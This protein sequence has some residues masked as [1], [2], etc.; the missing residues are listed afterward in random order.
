MNLF[1]ELLQRRVPRITSGF[2]V[3]GWGLLQFLTILESRMATPPHLVN[4]S[5]LALVLFLSSVI[6]L[7]WIHGRPGKDT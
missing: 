6:T 2:I 5:G 7:A 3:G 4:L 1:Q